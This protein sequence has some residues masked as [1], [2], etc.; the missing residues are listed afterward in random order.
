MAEIA[1]TPDPEA[2][3]H[4]A[5]GND[6]G[7]GMISFLDTADVGGIFKQAPFLQ[8]SG[9]GIGM[10]YTPVSGHLLMAAT[11][12]S[13][14]R[15]AALRPRDMKVLKLVNTGQSAGFEGGVAIPIQ[16]SP[17]TK[18]AYLVVIDSGN[19]SKL[20]EIDPKTLAITVVAT[21]LA[22]DANRF[23]GALAYS[24]VD[25]LIFCGMTT[26]NA[27]NCLVRTW[28]PATASLSSA[29]SIG[30]G[31]NL[32]MRGLYFPGADRFVATGFAIPA[33]TYFISRDLATVSTYTHL[34]ALASAT[35]YPVYSPVG[36]RVWVPI[37]DGAYR[38][39][40]M[41]KNFTLDVN[42]AMTRG[43]VSNVFARGSGLITGFTP[44]GGIGYYTT[45]DP[46]E[47]A[48]VLAGLADPSVNDV[49]RQ[50]ISF[51]PNLNLIFAMTTPVNGGPILLTSFSI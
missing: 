51:V 39:D 17:K 37:F 20:V 13:T 44:S 47:K 19:N 26:V 29:V 11:I 35:T 8:F 3:P 34:G 40:L 41:K 32:L 24:P 7:S 21:L 2:Q 38:Y 27:G 4:L 18:K 36:S 14:L 43:V 9:P 46:V 25:G 23:Y 30:A 10:V 15:L 28:N 31:I 42:V 6:P 5:L 45:C 12:G 50:E 49:P 33:V 1:I 16:Y 22:A 48:E